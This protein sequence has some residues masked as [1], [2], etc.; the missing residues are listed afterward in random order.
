ML[1][2]KLRKVV[3]FRGKFIS[4]SLRGNIVHQMFCFCVFLFGI[5]SFE[6]LSE[7]MARSFEFQTARFLQASSFP[8]P[9]WLRVSTTVPEAR[10]DRVTG[11]VLVIGGRGWSFPFF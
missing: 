11:H 4:G 10:I 2:K 6:G 5:L 1:P 7:W 8:P 3:F 9:D